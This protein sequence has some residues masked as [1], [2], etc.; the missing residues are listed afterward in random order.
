MGIV[1]KE[2]DWAEYMIESH[3]LGE[4]KYETLRRIARY[5]IDTGKYGSFMRNV[6][7]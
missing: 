7:T 3:S 1:L 5:Y 6:T 2:N 4:S